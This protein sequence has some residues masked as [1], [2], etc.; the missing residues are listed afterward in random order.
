MHIDLLQRRWGAA[1]GSKSD[2]VEVKFKDSTAK[3]QAHC[4]QGWLAV[5]A[6]LSAKR[7]LFP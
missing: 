1:G 7:I 4:W 2:G 6:T 5:L 3:K